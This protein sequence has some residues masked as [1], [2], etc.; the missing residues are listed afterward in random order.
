[1]VTNVRYRIGLMNGQ[2]RS[3]AASA[4]RFLWHF[5]Q[6]LVAM[7]VGM[8]IFHVFIGRP[9]EEYRILWYAGMELSMV[10]PMVG[11]MLFQRHGWRHSLEMAAAMLIGP[12]VFLVCAQFGWHNYIPGLTRN[13]LFTLADVTMFVGMLG[14]MLYRREMYTQPHAAH[15]HAEAGSVHVHHGS[16]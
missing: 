10:P 6:M 12:A 13:T 15:Q 5:L 16:A 3:M 11:L 4:G 8:M 2:V 1:M 14:A 7:M 9:A